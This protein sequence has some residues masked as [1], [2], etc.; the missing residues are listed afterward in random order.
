MIN[1]DYQFIFVRNPKT[2][3]TSILE[4]WS[5][6]Y[7]STSKLPDNMIPPGTD[8]WEY[9]TNHVFLSHMK[10]N[11]EH[12][13]YTSYFKFGF[14]RNPYDRLVSS[15]RYACDWHLY[16]ER[17]KPYKSFADFVDKL[18]VTR[19]APAETI[20]YGPQHAFLDGCDYVGKFET[21]Q[22]DYNIACEKMNIYPR[23]LS[24][25]NKAYAWR[26]LPK[27]GW[28]TYHEQNPLPRLDH[29]RSYYNEHIKSVVDSVFAQDIEIYQYRF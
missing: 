21:L 23:R 15:Y 11:M 24:H 7:I 27:H 6:G 2:G 12:D 9:D 29:Y 4:N 20:K 17:S 25:E 1:H 10:N 18:F 8:T 28:S 26:Y 16:F 14:V 13:D 5:P 19:S 22:R 3:S